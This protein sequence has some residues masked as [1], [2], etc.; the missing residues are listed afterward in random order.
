MQCDG[1]DCYRLITIQAATQDYRGCTS[2]QTPGWT[3]SFDATDAATL[4]YKVTGTATVSLHFFDDEADATPCYTSGTGSSATY[5]TIT[6]TAANLTG[7]GC[8]AQ[9]DKLVRVCGQCAGTTA[10]TCFVG[11]GGVHVE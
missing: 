2:L 6:A 4:R 1:A 10:D 5:A 9:V 3:A 11:K 8:T 7:A